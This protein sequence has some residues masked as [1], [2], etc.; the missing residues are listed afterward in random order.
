MRVFLTGATGLIGSHLAKYLVERGDDVV[1]LVR[2]TSDTGFLDSLE[3]DLVHGDVS[4]RVERL[5][6]AMDGC[7]HV[8]H[9]A[10]LVY[11]GRGWDAVAAVNVEGTRRVL[12]AAAASGAQK[13]VNISSVAVYSGSALEYDQD[14]TPSREAGISNDYARSKRE[15][16]VVARQVE[17]DTGL[18]VTTLRPSAVYGERDRL[19]GPAMERL[20]SSPVVPLFGPGDNTLPVVYAGNVAVAIGI[21]LD[22]PGGRDSYDL[23]MD[24][25]LSQKDFMYK[26]GLGMG[27]APRF[28]RLPAFLVRSGALLLSRMG[29]SPPGAKHLSLERLAR[30]ALEDNPYLSRRAHR[31]LGWDPP[32]RHDEALRRTGRW[33][34]SR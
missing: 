14:S 4:D 8:V 3:V 15:A 5:C 29:V 6:S 20:L 32:F 33:L 27:R 31:D 11:S 9:A 24:H 23:G 17:R 22:S 30:L 25:P 28:V 21:I 16:E 18:P 13:A 2:P 12:V 19:L 10:A 1:A 7:S 26:L 34:A